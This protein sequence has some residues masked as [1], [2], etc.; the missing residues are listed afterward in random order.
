MTH[1]LIT[2]I[3]LLQIADAWT[4]WRILGAGWRELN[5]LMAWVFDKLGVVPG[6]VL[7]KCAFVALL[8]GTAQQGSLPDFVLALLT[9]GHALVV[10]LNIKVMRG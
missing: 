5:P 10:A 3:V 7:T 2:L 9:I 1:I 6:L 8:V 4:T